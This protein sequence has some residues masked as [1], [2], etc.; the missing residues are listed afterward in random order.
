VEVIMDARWTTRIVVLAYTVYACHSWAV[1][2]NLHSHPIERYTTVGG[3]R[4]S[5]VFAGSHGDVTSVR[6]ASSIE[7]KAH[8][9]V[10]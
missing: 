7:P 6:N 1:M 2:P 3:A 4:F 5:D 9:K 10:I 8:H